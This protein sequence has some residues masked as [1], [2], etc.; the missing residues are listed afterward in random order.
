[1]LEKWKYK[2]MY[3]RIL[4]GVAAVA[5]AACF[6]ASANATVYTNSG[7]TQGTSAP[8]GS[9]DTTSYG[10]YFTAPGGALDSWSFLS[11]SAGSVGNLE[12]VVASWNGKAAVGPAL[13]TSAPITD[14]GTSNEA[15]TFSGINLAL[16]AGQSYIA[17]M[18]VAGV[19]S[20]VA[21]AVISVS[22]TDV[23]NGGS[24]F[25]NSNGANPLT[26]G[27]ITWD[28]PGSV[29]FTYSA[30]FVP[31]AVPEPAGAAVLA[32]GLIGLGFVRRRP[33]R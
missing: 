3:H 33:S 19:A 16:T 32:F 11:E 6:S 25:Y 23:L 20:P 4:G 24:A 10:E 8:F 22:S 28:A 31:A 26:A 30:T 29:Y 17:Y 27:N 21:G 18:T 5:F 13:Y 15:L 12:L 2:A 1:M 14:S 9:P 7:G